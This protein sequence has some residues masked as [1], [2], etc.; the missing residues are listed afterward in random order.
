MGL[1][2]KLRRFFI[3]VLIGY[4]LLFVACLGYSVF[5]GNEIESAWPA[6][7]LAEPWFGVIRSALGPYVGDWGWT[8]DTV[9]DYL[10]NWGICL[11]V[12]SAFINAAILYVPVWLCDRV[13]RNQK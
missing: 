12:A 4:A 10:T 6:Y 5:Q 3:L 7:V 2:P 9:H 1:I 8:T 11:L 13:A